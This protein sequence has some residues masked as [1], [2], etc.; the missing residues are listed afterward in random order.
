ML[1]EVGMV[2]RVAL[3]LFRYNF[4]LFLITSHVAGGGDGQEGGPKPGA[5]AAGQGPTIEEVD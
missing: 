1:Q 3:I 2:R 4:Y 5:G